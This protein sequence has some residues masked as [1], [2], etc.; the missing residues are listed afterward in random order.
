VP[1]LLLDL[2]HWFLLRAPDHEKSPT[3][4]QRRGCGR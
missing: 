3:A 1:E 2:C 4:T